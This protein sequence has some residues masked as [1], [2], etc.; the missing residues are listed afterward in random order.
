MW[1]PATLGFQT[2][3]VPRPSHVFNVTPVHQC[4]RLKSWEWA[5]AVVTLKM[6]EGL[7]TKLHVL[8]IHK[9][10]VHETLLLT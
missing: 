2:S 3:L 5:K 1:C 6:W 10:H 9:L 8:S 7:G 4:A